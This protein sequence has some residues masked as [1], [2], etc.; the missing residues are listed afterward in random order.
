MAHNQRKRREGLPE[1]IADIFQG[2]WQD[3]CRLHWQW[4]TCRTLYGSG[5]E[6]IDLLNSTAPDFFWLVERILLDAVLLSLARITD[7]VRTG[8][9]E[10]L[11]LN[12]LMESVPQNE[13]AVFRAELA[14]ILEKVRGSCAA[15]REIRHRRLAHCDLPT[16]LEYRPDPLPGLGRKA[17]EEALC[18]IRDFMNRVTAHY[19]DSTTWF[20]GAGSP[21]P[22][23]ELVGFL[24][25]AL[26]R[27]ETG[28]G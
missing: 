13:G 23:S 8:G 18:A 27:S 2:L 14:G 5:P 10:N 19:C 9:K 12:R 25:T 3:V 28:H 4:A 6:R 7:P 17:V 26:A 24:E 11:S 22:A 1:P 20:E 15:F 16:A 21:D